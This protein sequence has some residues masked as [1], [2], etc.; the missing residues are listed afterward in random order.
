[1]AFYGLAQARRGLFHFGL[2]KA[3]S[4]LLGVAL[5]VLT[6]RVTD[7]SV[8]GSLASLLAIVEIFYLVSGLGLSYHAQRLV[9]E[10]R[11]RAPKRQ[12]RREIGLMLFR[13]AW[14]GLAF[15]V[16]L[17]LAMPWWLPVLGIE[18]S[19][20]QRA[21]FV[22]MV[23]LGVMYRLAD[24]LLQSLMLQGWLQLQVVGRN[25][26]KLGVM[27]GALL[28]S[29]P[30]D[31]SLLLGIECLVALMSIA[32]SLR[33][34]TLEL[35]A[36]AKEDDADIP[37]DHGWGPALQYYGAQVLAQ[38]YGPSAMKLVVSAAL[39]TAAAALFSVAHQA[40]EM[41]RNYSP[42]F[43][44]AGW[45]RPLMVARYLESRRAAAI[46]PLSALVCNISLMGLL[47]LLAISAVFGEPIANMLGGLRYLAA[48]DLFAPLVAAVCVQALRTVLGMVCITLQ[49]PSA[50]MRATAVGIIALPAAAASAAVFGVAGVA[51]TCAASEVAW[52]LMV[53]WRLARHAPST[54]FVDVRGLLKLAVLTVAAWLALAVAAAYVPGPSWLW[55]VWSVLVALV[56]LL[57]PWKL[58]IFT[59][60]HMDWMRRMLKGDRR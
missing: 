28:V 7:M 59:A 2:G 58:G 38:A 10:L 49:Q 42:A 52:V 45:V 1:M 31:L 15:A 47:P 3:V 46:A 36:Q 14:L 20:G 40:V 17:A 30:V 23:L 35:R 26:L 39:G 24:E 37:M 27:A 29:T 13:R 22:A 48:A 33:I 11:A 18:L 60:Q 34:L 44:L 56:M 9:P 6:V 5:L 51:W 8:F 16:P 43:L 4:A 55:L 57:L 21:A 41:V 32:L 50:M 54:P 53:R 12:I 25:L 19:G